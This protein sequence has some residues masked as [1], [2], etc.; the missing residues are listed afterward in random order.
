MNLLNKL[1]SIFKKNKTY[2]VNHEEIIKQKNDLR[3]SFPKDLI[4]PKDGEVYISTCDFKIDYLTSHNA[5]FTGGDKAILPKGEQIKIRKPI[6]DQPINVYCDPINY[7]KI[8]NNIVTKE[9]RSNPTYDGYYFS[10]DTIDLYNHFI[11]KK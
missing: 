5:P 11:H 3:S 6:E 1:S 7:D 9:E 8:H 10:I 2:L 4:Y